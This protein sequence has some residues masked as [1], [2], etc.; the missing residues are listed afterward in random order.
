VPVE[1]ARLFVAHLRRTSPNPVVYAELPGAQ[2]SFER[3]HSLRFVRTVDTIEDFAN[4]A[5]TR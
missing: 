4:W 2:H 5:G 3:F 1:H